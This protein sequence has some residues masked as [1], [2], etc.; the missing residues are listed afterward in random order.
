MIGTE[1]TFLERNLALTAGEA[2]SGLR[3]RVGTAYVPASYD[4]ER[5]A[6]TC[7]APKVRI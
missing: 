2:S 1:G 3:C 6:V 5:Q 7:I 4:A